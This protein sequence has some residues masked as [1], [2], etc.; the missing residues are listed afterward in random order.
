MRGVDPP[1]LFAL[2]KVFCFRWI[3]RSSM[4]MTGVGLRARP[5]GNV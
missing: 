3:A 1:I 4:M 5:V 2:Q